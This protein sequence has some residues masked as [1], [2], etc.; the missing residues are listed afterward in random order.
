MGDEKEFWPY[1]TQQAL[2]DL[3][4]LGVQHVNDILHRRKGCAKETALLLSQCSLEAVGTHIPWDVFLW[5]KSA[6]H[7]A[8]FGDPV[9]EGD[10]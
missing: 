6:R 9:R 10:K 2:A 4:G 8:L 5:N 7:P 3:T 1:G